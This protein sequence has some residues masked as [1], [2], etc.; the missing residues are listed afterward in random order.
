MTNQIKKNKFLQGLMTKEYLVLFYQSSIFIINNPLSIFNL[1]ASADTFSKYVV[2]GLR[3]E[4]FLLLHTYKYSIHSLPFSL[5]STIFSFL[6]TFCFIYLQYISILI[7]NNVIPV[8]F[9]NL[10]FYSIEFF[11]LLNQIIMG[12]KMTKWQNKSGIDKE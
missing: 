4:R 1:F 12:E 5:V 3:A 9:I 11:H 8:L 6:F 10:L 7:P 2:L